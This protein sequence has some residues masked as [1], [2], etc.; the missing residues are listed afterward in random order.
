V[1]PLR[2]YL[3]DGADPE[4]AI[5]TLTERANAARKLRGEISRRGRT[6]K[7]DAAYVIERRDQY[8]DWVEATETQLANLTDDTDVLAIAYMPAYYE[9]RHSLVQDMSPRPVAFIDAEI[10]R[11]ITNLQRLRDDLASIRH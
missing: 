9:I 4:Q 10:A 2:L 1:Q 8:V 3:K 6:S 5:A 7:D 11:Q